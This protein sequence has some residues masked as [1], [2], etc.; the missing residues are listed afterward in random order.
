MTAPL[1][2][3]AAMPDRRRVLRLMA[4]LPLLRG[5]GNAMAGGARVHL[6][7]LTAPVIP[8]APF[9]DG[10]RVL[11]AGPAQGPLSPWGRRLA[12]A[13]PVGLPPGSRVALTPMGGGDGV[14]AANQFGA[15]TGDGHIL[16][17]TPGATVLAW[18]VGEGRVKFDVG[19]WVPVCAAASPALLMGRFEPLALRAGQVL[20]LAVDRLPGPELAGLL[21]LALLGA[22]PR[23]VPGLD[24]AAAEAALLRGALDAVLLTGDRVVARAARLRARGIRPI[25]SF[26]A[27]GPDGRL[28]RDPDFPTVPEVAELAAA[29]HGGPADPPLMR[30][31]RATAAAAQLRFGLDLP[32]LT[33]AGMVALWR[34]AGAAAMGAPAVAGP[35]TSNGW[36]S[37]TGS[38]A[39]ANA[40]ALA[41]DTPAL[42]ALRHWLSSRRTW[43]VG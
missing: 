34:R 30:A 31:W 7:P 24:R 43:R 28:R 33:P 40:R 38:A 4:S 13:L 37:L 15:R 29:L 42:L 36:R 19:G 39:L 17:L 23:P 18:L 9:R 12:A 14:T 35:L 5:P 16:L 11:M 32:A 21:A 8:A 6:V 10:A 20:R 2:D 26:G 3:P 25:A 41:A 27:F 22:R 1:D